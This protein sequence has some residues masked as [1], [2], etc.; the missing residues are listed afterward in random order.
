M[1]TEV[2]LQVRFSAVS[3]YYN[4]KVGFYS[5]FEGTM[6]RNFELYKAVYMRAFS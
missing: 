2:L 3:F 5:L 4:G 6:Q 1:G